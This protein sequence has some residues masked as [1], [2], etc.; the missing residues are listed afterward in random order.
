MLLLLS[1]NLIAQKEQFKNYTIKDGL[2]QSDVFDAIQDH[3]GYLWFATQGGGIAKFDGE[4]FNIFNQ[5]NG[6][7]SNYVNSFLLQKDTLLIGTDK[8]LSR[9]TQNNF[10]SFKTPE[11][12]KIIALNNHIYLATDEGIYEYKYDYVIPIKVNLKIDLSPI[13]NI[14]YK[15]A[16]YW[17]VTSK[18]I[19]KVKTLNQPKKIQKATLKEKRVIAASQKIDFKNISIDDSIKSITKKIFT[20]KQNNIWLLTLGNGIYKSTS[21]N[22]TH[23]NKVDNLT[24]RNIT[25]TH[26][27]N[28][29]L[30]FTDSN[31]NLFYTDSL[32]VKKVDNNN[33]KTTSI[34][35]DKNNHLW[36]GS[37]KKG[38]YIF[39]KKIDTLH[40]LNFDIERLHTNNGLP[41]NNIKNIHIQNDTVWVVT[42]N[43]GIIK[44]TYDFE[45]K[46]VKKISRFNSNNGIKDLQIT[47]SL[48]YN[49]NL[50]YGTKNGAIGSISNNS[51]IHYSKILKQKIP[52]SSITFYNDQL[53]VGTLGNGI[54][55]SNKSNINQIQPLKK[56]FLSSLN[57]YQ[58][59]FDTHNNLWIGSEKGLDKLNL[60]STI[61][62]KSTHYN[63]NDGFI[64]IETSKSSAINDKL[65]NLWFGTKNGITK[66]TPSENQINTQRPTI[67]FE[68]ITVANQSIN[69]IQRKYLDNILQLSPKQNQLSF[70][71]KT[72]D[73][74]HPK[75]VKYKWTLNDVSGLWTSSNSINF[76][77]LQ[78]GNYTFSV[79]S[80]NAYKQESTSKT[81]LFFIN[82]PLYKKTW[83][84]W[85]LFGFIA[86]VLF[87]LTANYLQRIQRKNDAKIE[88]LT[89][90]NH[91][92][93]LEQKALQLQMNPHFIF[94]VLNGIKAL[95][96]KGETEA[97]N[98][99]VSQFAILLRSILQNSRK[100]EI[101][102]S[103]EIATLKT[104]LELEKQLSIHTFE[105]EITTDTQ[106]IDTE[107]ILIPPMLL[108]PFVENSIKHGF[109]GKTNDG[110]ISLAFKVKNEFLYCSIIDNGIGFVQS[111]KQKKVS[112]HQS[113]AL[114]VTK[115]RIK[116]LSKQSTFKIVEL[117]ENDN[118]LGTK[119]TF[120]I[121]LITDY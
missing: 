72:V 71:Y 21:N 42:K 47:T 54:W 75:Q 5:D 10:T 112:N 92:I 116:N 121:P 36:L 50:W 103:D 55:V 18:N 53:F 58:M 66:Y 83:F 26:Y 89:L 74:N 24:I 7:I 33:F 90:D 82:T 110:K 51:V 8:G 119:V 104:Y 91:L 109:K 38:I 94:N 20:D 76:A 81:Y 70:S 17:I 14:I 113:L 102:L 120:K 77:N 30:W 9:K 28:D 78:P 23:F 35:T 84:I 88:R 86:I 1:I 73:V 15:N 43:I 108:Q 93:T 56:A 87:I 3:I 16:Y 6:L 49:N 52:I 29:T 40:N 106:N 60:K 61:V 67:F 27:K 98:K 59:V 12:H 22:F 114:K 13:L 65:G 19:W 62:V 107:E 57:V 101:S 34:T 69:S 99:T 31:R 41:N 32:S 48:L 96:N 85:S 117:N 25:A 68:D 80:R 4:H 100:E 118:I 95:G 64:G 115:E 105:F 46:F 97:L 37:E 11:I 44:L 63:A 39:R 2:P 79:T 45:N 111:Q